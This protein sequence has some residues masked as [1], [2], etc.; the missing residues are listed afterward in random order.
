MS[1]IEIEVGRI[2]IIKESVMDRYCAFSAD[3]AGKVC[4]IADIHIV[5]DS[6]DRKEC[7]IHAILAKLDNVID[8]VVVVS[9]SPLI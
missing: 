4:R 5:S 1:I 9:V 6:V 3:L 7:I 2:D 8:N